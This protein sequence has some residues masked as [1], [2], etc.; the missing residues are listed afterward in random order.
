VLASGGPQP[1][2]T[3]E[4]SIG[5]HTVAAV[6]QNGVIEARDLGQTMI[7]AKAVGFDMRS[8]PVIY[9]QVVTVYFC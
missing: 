9:S 7:D 6:S 8:Q 5:N 4:F 1:D 2:S 3:I